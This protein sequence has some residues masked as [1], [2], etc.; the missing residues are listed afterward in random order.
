MTWRL[1]AGYSELTTH[2]QQ[3]VLH[4]LQRVCIHATLQKQLSGLQHAS[5]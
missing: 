2:L 4:P 1:G 3:Q 5:I